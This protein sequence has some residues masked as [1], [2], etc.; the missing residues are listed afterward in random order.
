MQLG[1]EN[2]KDCRIKDGLLNKKGQIFMLTSFLAS[3]IGEV[4]G[5]G[6]GS[7]MVG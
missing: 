3:W 1:P 5:S 6:G 4:S 2:K 7:W